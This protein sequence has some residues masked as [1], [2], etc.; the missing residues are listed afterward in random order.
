M[1]FVVGVVKF[2]TAVV[3]VLLVRFNVEIGLYVIENPMLVNAMDE[4]IAVFKYVSGL[5][6]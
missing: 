2:N 5:E 4:L 3:A 6:K 1:P